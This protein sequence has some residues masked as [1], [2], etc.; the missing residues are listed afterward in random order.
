M[1]IDLQFRT[2]ACKNPTMSDAR[3]MVMQLF[4]GSNI[5][6]P[7]NRID[8]FDK[9]INDEENTATINDIIQNQNM[10]MTKWKLSDRIADI[11]QQPVRILNATVGKSYETK[12]D[13]NKFGWDD[14]TKFEFAGL[15]AAG[16]W[17]DDKTRQITGVPTQS[18]DI[19]V[20]FKF[21]IEVEPEEAPFNEKIITL[22]INPDPKKLWK[23]LPSDKNDPYWKEDDITVFDRIAD[24]HIL[25]SSKRGRAHANVGSFREDDF[26]FKDLQNGWSI[27]VVADG[28]A[29][30]PLL[31]T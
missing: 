3:E 1:T 20:I 22:I 26:A 19:K 21:K 16:L 18:G 25:V 4:K 7:A 23:N 2:G 31:Q 6:V 30:S 9:F 12:F 24:R 13:F 5:N 11:M 8:L 10:L 17:F 14:I 29:G 27:V 28:Q 15:D